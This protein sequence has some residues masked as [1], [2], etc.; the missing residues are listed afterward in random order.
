MM[1]R[2]VNLKQVHLKKSFPGLVAALLVARRTNISRDD[3]VNNTIMA[4]GHVIFQPLDPT[5]VD[6]SS[7]KPLILQLNWVIVFVKRGVRFFHY[8]VIYRLEQQKPNGHDYHH[9]MHSVCFWPY[10]STVRKMKLLNKRG[11]LAMSKRTE[12]TRKAFEVFVEAQDTFEVILTRQHEHKK[13]IFSCEKLLRNSPSALP[14][15]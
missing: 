7:I 3:M 1:R 14:E 15:K 4:L 11:G 10:V 9:G 6:S 8:S 12:L 2:D 13:R 5:L